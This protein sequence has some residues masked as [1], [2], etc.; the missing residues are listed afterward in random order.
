[1]GMRDMARPLYGNLACASLRLETGHAGLWYD[2]FCD[3][4]SNNWT[5][6]AS[7]ETDS[8]K[9]AWIET[10]TKNPVGN[11]E[12]IEEAISR[13]LRLALARG[14]LFGVLVSES[15]F[16]TGLGRSHPVE[17][18][19]AWHPTLGVPYL[20]GSSVKGM[21]RDWAEREAEP[22]PS[23]DEVKKIFGSRGAVGQIDVLDLLPLA[24]VRL[25]A[26]VTTPHYGGWTPEAPPAD[27][28][29]PVPVPFLVTAIGVS[30]AFALLPRSQTGREAL[31]IVRSWLTEA[32][33]WAGAGAKTSVGYGRFRLDEDEA[34]KWRK[35]AEDTR[36]AKAENIQRA[37]MVRT[38]EGRWQIEIQGRSERDILELVRV[39][40]SKEPL[41]DP[42]E[43]RALARAVAATGLPVLWRKGTK[44]DRETQ[45]GAAKLKERAKLI[46]GEMGKEN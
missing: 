21:I 17:S 24:P 27:W 20:P 14:G 45:V 46:E 3:R 1:M 8:K 39:H 38:P 12:M 11:K 36:A 44:R 15:R 28:C 26:D 19:F 35:R 41:S 7:G 31:G 37:E 2:K 32:I 9:L 22:S 42:A 18:G 16:V 29:G 30:F 5:L 40:L 33:V 43:R 34:T 23:L 6:E 10:V 4:W 13:I 25:E